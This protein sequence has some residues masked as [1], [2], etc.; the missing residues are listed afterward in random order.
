MMK[1]L[2]FVIKIHIKLIAYVIYK[3]NFFIFKKKFMD[4]NNKDFI[5]LEFKD[6]TNEDEP[7][8]VEI[9]ETNEN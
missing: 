1:F 6:Y 4:K 8:K 5:S 7:H 9:E 2:F 3:F